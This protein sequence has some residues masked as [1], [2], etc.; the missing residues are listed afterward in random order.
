MVFKNRK[1][2]IAVVLLFL[3]LLGGVFWQRPEEKLKLVFC[4]VGQGDAVLAIYDS[5]QVLIDG[6]PNESVLSCLAHNLPFWDRDLEMVVL[7]HPEADHLT[8]LIPVIER[9]NVKQFIINSIAND[10]LIFWHFREQVLK[11]GSVIYS[12]QAGDT[13]KLGPL[14][15]QVLWPETKLDS[16]LV[17]QSSGE[18]D[19]TLVLGAATYS[20]ELN[21]SS[22]VLKLSYGNFD[23]LLTGD[24]GQETEEA[25]SLLPVEVLKV[26]HHGSRFSTSEAFLEKVKPVLAV[27]SVGKNSFG[28]PTKEVLTKLTEQGIKVLRTDQAGEI[29]IGS[30]GQKWWL[31]SPLE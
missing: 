11:E 20:G 23:A 16:D 21:E 5:L 30:D 31:N 29:S 4:D 18:S 19:K 27:I 2:F 14:V 26:A 10:S 3:G 12:P 8:G 15:F 9:Y 6:G 17:W 7:T 1:T 22:I 28:H 13:L 25:I 24:I